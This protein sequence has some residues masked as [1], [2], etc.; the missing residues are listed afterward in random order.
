MNADDELRQYL[1][2]SPD[3][4]ALNMP[5]AVPVRKRETAVAMTPDKLKDTRSEWEIQEALYGLCNGYESNMN[6]DLK[7]LH[8]VE[9]AKGQGRPPAGAE[10][11][12]GIPDNFLPVPVE[13]APG[14][15]WHG[16]YVE[17]KRPGK[18]PRSEQL[19]RMRQ[20]RADGYAVA[21]FVNEYDAFRWLKLYLAGKCD[22][23]DVT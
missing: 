2:N 23:G 21:W 13:F 18:K 17:L 11:A 6:H 9:N 12:K 15:W 8:P 10:Y 5:E 3:V 22:I 20:L 4:A 16:A 19:E 7:K 1:S 14:L